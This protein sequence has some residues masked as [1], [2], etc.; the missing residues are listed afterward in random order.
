MDLTRSP[1]NARR[2][3]ADDGERKR[4]SAYTAL[5]AIHDYAEAAR[6]ALRSNDDNDA[7]HNVAV[8]RG[9]AELAAVQL[10]SLTPEYS[11]LR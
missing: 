1:G 8:L 9:L 5:L 6:D 11:V 10:H 4:I 3:A 7:R 2:T